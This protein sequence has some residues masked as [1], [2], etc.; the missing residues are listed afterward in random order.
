M[1][2]YACPDLQLRSGGIA[3]LYRHVRLLVKNGFDAAILH[4]EAGFSVEAEEE[5]PTRY[6]QIPCLR[7]GDVI[8]LP[9]GYPHLMNLFKNLPVRRFAI[10]LNW[11][12]VYRSLLGSRDYRAFNIERAIVV[13][14]FIGRFVQWAMGIPFSLVDYSI[15]TRLY[16]QEP[17]AKT[18]SICFIKRKAERIQ[19]LLGILRSRD[20]RYTDQIEWKA[21]DELSV[22]RYAAEVRSSSVFLN[23]S[24]T[25]GLPTSMLEAMSAGCIVAGYD[26]VGGQEILVGEGPG[27]NAVLAQ[28][29]DYVSLAYRLEPLL[30]GILS[31]DL[32]RWKPLVE[33]GRELVRPHTLESEERSLVQLWTEVL[34][35]ERGETADGSLVPAVPSTGKAPARLP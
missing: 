8:V 31:G 2:L 7:E 9:E 16:H 24:P 23:L 13:S 20:P 28:C 4:N 30:E 14:P 12:Y 3:R 11:D 34:G 32:T 18:P 17:A 29:G 10:C 21:L 15:D 5:V 27:Q 1:I 6:L 35:K 33:R 25:E 19:P 22:E 26:G